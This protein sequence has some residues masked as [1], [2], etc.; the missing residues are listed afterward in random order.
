MSSPATLSPAA[1]TWRDIPQTIAPRAMSSTGRKRMMF[2]TSK[3]VAGAILVLACL[4][5]GYTLFHT[6]EYDP[7]K[8]KAPVKSAV[9]KN[10]SLRGQNL[11]LDQPWLVRTLNL[12]KDADL[13]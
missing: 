13:V 4:W 7:S 9:V 6:W 10:I 12:P 8:L 2:A 1:R 3:N 11:V 5:V